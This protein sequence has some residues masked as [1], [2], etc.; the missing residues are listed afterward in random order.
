MRRS[1]ECSKSFVDQSGFKVYFTPNLRRYDAMTLMVGAS[2]DP[3]IVVPPGRRKF[4]IAGHAD[5]RCLGPDYRY[6]PQ[7][8]VV[9]PGD[10]L[11]V[12]C[13]YDSTGRNITTFGG[14]GTGQEMCLA[15]IL[16]YPRIARARSLSS[17]TCDLVKSLAGLDTRNSNSDDDNS[18]Y[19]F[20]Q[21]FHTNNP[22]DTYYAGI[23][24]AAMR[25]G[26]HSTQCYLGDGRRL[27]ISGLITYP[28]NIRPYIEPAKCTYIEASRSQEQWKDNFLY[29]TYSAA[30]KIT[31]I[32]TLITILCYFLLK[33]PLPF[34]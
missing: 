2:V 27:Q 14:L 7:E 21:H 29:S 24:E 28:R 30:S 3:C 8:V 18:N 9:K 20:Y 33:F 26:Y 11:T 10:H 22:W 1:Q 32:Y 13:T 6:L 19:T 34:S 12:E 5:P 16:Y 31:S 4:T 15:F 17:A 23:A 25:F